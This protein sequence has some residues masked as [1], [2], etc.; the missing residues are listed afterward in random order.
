V[1]SNGKDQALRLW[2]LRKMKSSQE[3]DCMP[4]KHYGIPHWDYRSGAYQRPRF[5][6]HPDDCS[7]MTYRGHTVLRTLIRCHFSPAVT[8]GGSY[9][10]SG[11]ADGKIHIWSL[12][13]RIVQVL[14]RAHVLPLGCD[15]SGAQPAPESRPVFGGAIV[16]DVSWHSSEPVLMSSAWAN[17]RSKSSVARHEWKGLGRNGMR[18]EDV[19]E[20]ENLE[21]REPR[22][23]GA[24]QAM[25]SEE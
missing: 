14:D 7:V 15:A 5:L 6:A 17:Q 3:F 2:D 24:F 1:I 10:Y 13:G 22:M 25:G 16:R 12:D 19:V 20:K 9:I 4:Q 11:S 21:L 23:P 8:T 18:L